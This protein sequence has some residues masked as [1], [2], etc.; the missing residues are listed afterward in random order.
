LRKSKGIS[1]ERLAELSGVSRV[2]IARIETG[3]ISPNVLTLEK[4]C[5]ALGVTLNDVCER[6]G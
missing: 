2:T 5:C 1:Q 3:K 4:L 6:A